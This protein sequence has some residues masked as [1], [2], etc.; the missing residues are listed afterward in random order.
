M[1]KKKI[2]VETDTRAHMRSV[3]LCTMYSAIKTSPPYNKRLFVVKR[4]ASQVL[5]DVEESS[6]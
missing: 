3:L 1:K 2:N 4:V 5:N 6:D